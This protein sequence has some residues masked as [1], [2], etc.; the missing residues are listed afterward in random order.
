MGKKD[1]EQEKSKKC[2]TSWLLYLIIG[3]LIAV[4]ILGLVLLFLLPVKTYQPGKSKQ[5]VDQKALGTIYNVN[6]NSVIR[7]DPGLLPILKPEHNL[8]EVAKELLLTEDHLFQPRLSCVQ[9]VKK[10]FLTIEAL[11]EET[12]T[13][14][15]KGRYNAWLPQYIEGIRIFEAAFLKAQAEKAS[16]IPL[17]KSLR[18]IRKNLVKNFFS[19]FTIDRPIPSDLSLYVAALPSPIPGPS[20]GFYAQPVVDVHQPGPPKPIIKVRQV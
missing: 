10:H 9:C 12:M 13:L 15:L 17:A 11:L 6:P 16:Y 20:D 14:D 4:L 7:V 2:K 8:R 18:M 1:K 19:S 5:N 3:L